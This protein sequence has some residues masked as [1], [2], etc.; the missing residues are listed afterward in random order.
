MIADDLAMDRGYETYLRSRTTGARATALAELLGTAEGF[1]KRVVRHWSRGPIGEL[2]QEDALQQAR[3]GFV[4]AVHRCDPGRG[5]LRPFAMS[6][7]R[8]ELQTLAESSSTIKIPRRS[9]LSAGVLKQIEVIRVREGREPTRAELNGH[10]QAYDEAAL[11]PHVVTSFDAVSVSAEHQLSLSEKVASD[12]GSALDALIERESEAHS[13]RIL[14]QISPIVSNPSIHRLSKKKTMT[15]HSDSIVHEASILPSPLEA[16]RHAMAGVQD[17]LR[18]L[19]ER[20]A[21]VRRE[22]EQAEAEVAKVAS[23]L[24]ITTS[25]TVAPPVSNVAAI[26]PVIALGQDKVQHRVVR[27]LKENPASRIS[28]IAKGLGETSE[29]VAAALTKLRESKQVRSEG[30]ARGTAYSLAS[31]A[32]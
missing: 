27:F 5:P 14:K 13:T 3:I 8:H 25:A 26:R 10:A 15:T 4:D 2:E 9:G 11:R 31:R 23:S 17:H 1:I 19:K 22:R 20:E 7:I 12:A 30:K 21:S 29:T 16:L 28:A 24:G 6:R 18:I 32:A